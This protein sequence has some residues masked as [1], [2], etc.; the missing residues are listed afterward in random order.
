MQ[1]SLYILSWTNLFMRD[2]TQRFRFPT[3]EFL[4]DRYWWPNMFVNVDERCITGFKHQ[5]RKKGILLSLTLNSLYVHQYTWNTK[6]YFSSMMLINC[7][8]YLFMSSWFICMNGFKFPYL[9]QSIRKL[10]IF[11][12]VLVQEEQLNSNINPRLIIVLYT[13]WNYRIVPTQD[14]TLIA[15]N[16]LNNT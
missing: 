11:P 10:N 8:G 7:F 15:W 13:S 14:N 5:I 6:T 3:Y 4:G 12:I 1:F 2:T 9:V 16:H